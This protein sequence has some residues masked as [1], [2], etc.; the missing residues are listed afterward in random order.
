MGNLRDV[1]ATDAKIANKK[2]KTMYK[3]MFRK[4]SSKYQ[5]TNI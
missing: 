2:T 1:L 3:R 4:I 5:Q